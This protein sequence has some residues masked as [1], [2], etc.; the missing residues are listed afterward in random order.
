MIDRVAD[1][2]LY[3]TGRKMI[4]HEF[5]EERH[6]VTLVSHLA[7]TLTEKL[8]GGLGSPFAG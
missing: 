6:E 7:A 4:P 1:Q 5:I 3:F 2:L 8:I